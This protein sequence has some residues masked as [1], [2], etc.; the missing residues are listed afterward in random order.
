NH[1]GL[2]LERSPE[3]AFLATGQRVRVEASITSQ[4]HAPSTTISPREILKKYDVI[5]FVGASKS[6][7]KEAYTAPAYMKEHGYAIIPVNPTADQILGEKAYKS[8]TDLPPE[9]AKKVDI[10]DGIRPNEKLPRDAARDNG[11]REE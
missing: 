3:A 8:L 11:E 5:A 7:E 9:L 1:Y 10:V 6:P 2:E 4:A